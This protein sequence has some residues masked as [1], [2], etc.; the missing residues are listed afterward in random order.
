MRTMQTEFP[1]L[2]PLTDEVSGW[3]KQNGFKDNSWHNDE[4]PMFLN[5]SRG[6]GL[7]I[8]GDKIKLYA[9]FHYDR[10]TEMFSDDIYQT[11]DVNKLTARLAA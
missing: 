8:I 4:W 11:F 1:E 3:M 5:E 6:L 2:E 9:L 7:W 10:E